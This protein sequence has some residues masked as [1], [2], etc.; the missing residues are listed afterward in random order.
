MLRFEL[1]VSATIGRQMETFLVS[2]SYISLRFL[3]IFFTHHR[4][5]RTAAHT[6]RLG[7]LGPSP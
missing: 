3:G 4:V 6:S 2:A 1:N 7:F 5:P